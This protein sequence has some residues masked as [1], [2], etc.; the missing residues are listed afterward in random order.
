M[1]ALVAFL[2]CEKVVVD[3]DSHT[4]SVFSVIQDLNI[5]LPPGGANIPHGA[6]AQFPWAGLTLW[7]MVPEDKGK[8]F[9]QKAQ[10]TM[11]GETLVESDPAS[12]EMAKP[13]YRVIHRFLGFPIWRSGRCV[14]RLLLREVGQPEWRE[15]ATYPIR[16]HHVAAG[17]SD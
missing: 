8:A 13:S 14:L 17:A 16:V 5:P 11:E 2:G 10:L 7:E 6:M 9:E 12:F 1:P 3:Q 15:I 4:I